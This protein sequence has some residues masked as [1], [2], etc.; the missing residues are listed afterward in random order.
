MNMNKG[1]LILIPTP[2]DEQSSLG[3]EAFEL[4]LNCKDEDLILIEEAKVAR[5]RWLNWGLPRE[6]ISRFFE[7]N[8]HN[9]KE[10]SPILEKLKQGHN[11][12]LMSDG[13]LPAFCDP[14][15]LLVDQ[16]HEQKIQVTS[17][18]FANSISLTVALSGF[19]HKE[20]VFLGFLPRDEESIDQKLNKYLKEP[21]PFIFMD[22][23]YRLEKTIQGYLKIAQRLGIRRKM[24]L[25]LD[26]NTPEELLLRGDPADIL[27]KVVGQKREFVVMIGPK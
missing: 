11:V 24:F 19:D 18:P 8:E 1:K 26:L 10:L 6:A 5:K 15:Q 16:C 12:F 20:F 2:I 22:T 3:K 17:T 13:G 14:G 7:F 23:P 21:M 9:Q 27:K 4:L 25:A